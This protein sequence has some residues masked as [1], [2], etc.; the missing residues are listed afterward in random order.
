MPIKPLNADRACRRISP[1][2]FRFESSHELREPQGILGQDRAVEALEFGLSV[3][4]SGYNLFVLGPPASGRHNIV[5]QVLE[6][7]AAGEAAPDDWIYVHNFETP[8]KPNAIRL[9]NGRASVLRHD[10]QRF[11]DEVS[12]AL[13]AV[14]ETD[15]YRSSREAIESEFRNR[16]EQAFAAIGEE[17]QRRGLGLTRTSSG[18]AVA[19]VRDG[20]VMSPEQ[21]HA[22]PDEERARIE[23]DI[24]ELQERLKA[25]GQQLPDWDR[26]R[27]R[28][29][30]ELNRKV[31]DATVSRIILQL[32]TS[33]ADVAEVG[34]YL[35]TVRQDV[36]DNAESFLAA[37]QSEQGEAQ[38]ATAGPAQAIGAA[39]EQAR[40]VAR[41]VYRRYQVNIMVG[42]ASGDS[43][44][45]VHEQSPTYG[46]LIGRIEHMA[47]MGALL[48][49]FTLIKPGALHRANGGYL[50]L[51]TMRLLQQPYA[52]EGLKR[53]LR[54]GAVTIES[55]GQM[56]SQVSTI[57][58]EPEPIPLDL[59]VVLIGDQRLYYLLCRTDPDFGE[60]FKVAAEFE[61]DLPTDRSSIQRFSRLL[62]SVARKRELRGLDPEGMARVVEHSVRLAGDVDKLSLQIGHIGDLL[63]EADYWGERNGARLISSR[64]IQQAI[65]AHRR[66]SDRIAM[67]MREAIEKDTVLIATDGAEVGQINGLAVLSMG[68]F[69]FGK[70]NRITARVRLGSG[71]VIDIERRVDLG[72]PLHSKG[73][74]ILA[75]F[76]GARFAADHP[77]SLSASL[78][79]E[80]SYGGVDGDSASSAELYALLSALSDLPIKQGFAVTGSV[81]QRGEVQAIG[82]VNEKIEGFFDLCA[83]RGLT[84]EQGVLIPKSNV[85]HLMLKAEV[86]EAIAAGTFSVYPVAH[87]DQGIEILTGTPAGKANAKGGFPEGSVNRRVQDRVLE[88]AEKRRSFGRQGQN[89]GARNNGGNAENSNET[90]R[91]A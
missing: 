47:E 33:Y 70:P 86:V 85:R 29:L 8:H 38:S 15:E 84:G 60:L 41:A 72:G 9:P 63:T 91:K 77:L 48:T 50:F 89:N 83:A 1:K 88:L 49:D 2:Q 66:R 23:A 44:P 7:R 20:E 67:R 45:V 87:I 73:V 46:N 36:I 37:T 10:M 31:T 16:H 80:Q 71:E 55:P 64:E 56:M 19:P 22:L 14:F 39:A 26:E 42:E 79:F 6:Q 17:A 62:A 58:L 32:K 59:K 28:L 61:P 81:N 78:V 53:T 25:T 12:V 68:N 52:W 54:A 3:R 76:L 35:D 82:G 27:R 75:G 24:S 4:Q 74:L 5:Q 21:F 57:S 34:R 11:V 40:P 43:A 69:S 13:P 65:D 30:R 18:L 51:D 90:K